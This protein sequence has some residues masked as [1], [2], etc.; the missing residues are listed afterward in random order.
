[1]KRLFAPYLTCALLIFAPQAVSAQE[2]ISVMTRNLYLGA[3]LAPI[4]SAPTPAAFGQAVVAALTQI[5]A[6]N[7]PERAASLAREIVDKRPH[8]VGFQEVFTVTLNGSTGAPPYRD[9]LADLLEALSAQGA[10]YNVVARVQNLNVLIPIPG[11]G[12]VAATD[13]DVVLARADVP[14]WTVPLSGCQAS[15]DG[16]NYDTVV[17]L[18]T[19]VGPISLERGFVVVDA[20]VDGAR[21][22]RLANTHLEI[23]ELPPQ[24]QAAQAA[25]LIANL[26]A[27]PD[28]GGPTIVV[29]DIN[30]APTDQTITIGGSTIVPPYAQL[31]AAFS[32]AWLLRPGRPGGFTC[33]ELSNLSNPESMLF[34][35]VDV[36]FTSS[37]PARVK[38]NVL[39]VNQDDKTAQGLWPSDHAG[40]VAELQ[41]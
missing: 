30:S 28:P 14:A 40:V 1:M 13:H 12:L 38:A 15:L 20:L 9:Y 8:L 4:L 2:P 25:Q 29:G 33:C 17:T 6:N 24:F 19:A 37:M 41:F 34:K 21:Q 11:L 5:A 23:P 31:A 32:D 10:N 22:V 27:L 16:C 36:V 7:F 39:G 35:R 18:N 26:D 3:D